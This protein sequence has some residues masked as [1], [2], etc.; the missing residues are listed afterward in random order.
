MMLL[1]TSSFSYITRREEKGD[2][3]GFPKSHTS[4]SEW[5]APSSS[6][7]SREWS[8]A[9]SSSSAATRSRI[10]RTAVGFI[11]STTLHRG[12]KHHSKTAG[13]TG[14]F[15]DG[16]MNLPGPVKLYAFRCRHVSFHVVRHS[17]ETDSWLIRLLLELACAKTET[18]SSA[19]SCFVI[20]KYSSGDIPRFIPVS[21]LNVSSIFVWS[22]EPP[23]V[24]S[25]FIS[26]FSSSRWSI[27][28]CRDFLNQG[29]LSWSERR[30]GMG[31]RTA[32]PSTGALTVSD[33][34]Q[35]EGV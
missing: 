29:P 3:S 18:R 9:P 13:Q 23:P 1:L 22:G 14:W 2:G 26:I 12:V 25:V 15:H 35:L 31:K 34:W 16:W 5:E 30:S 6:S 19:R 33:M 4:F 11:F 8:S 32:T 21:S 10:E 7:S 24:N 17:E 27:S 28:F 20:R